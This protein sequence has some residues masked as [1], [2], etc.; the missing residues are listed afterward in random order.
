LRRSTWEV[1]ADRAK[2]PLANVTGYALIPGYGGEGL[3]NQR[4][5]RLAFRVVITGTADH[6]HGFVCAYSY[7][8]A[9]G[10][11]SASTM[12]PLQPRDL[13]M[14]GPCAGVVD[15]RGTAHWLYRS[16]RTSFYTLEN[17]SGASFCTLDVSANA[18]HVSLTKIPIQQERQVIQPPFPCVTGGG[19]LSI[20]SIRQRPNK[21]VLQVWTKPDQDENNQNWVHFELPMFPISFEPFSI[22][23]TVIGFAESKGA[24]LLKTHSSIVSL[25]LESRELR[26]VKGSEHNTNPGH[27][28]CSDSTSICQG[29]NSCPHCAYNSCLFYDLDWSSYLLHLSA[30]NPRSGATR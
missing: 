9:V 14:S 20:V 11:W 27:M 8:S 1:P 19:K 18:L 16:R 22:V 2:V 4:Q 25:D 7:S 15:D 21:V 5:R 24:L 3:D 30:W 17:W 23:V 29:Y 10:R 12:Y 6:L 26:L 28:I 13:I